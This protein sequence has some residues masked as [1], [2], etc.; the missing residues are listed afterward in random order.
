M[1]V[2]AITAA[3]LTSNNKSDTSQCDHPGSLTASNDGGC[4]LSCTPTANI[5][6]SQ[7][8][9]ATVESGTT[10]EFEGS[11]SNCTTIGD[12]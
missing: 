12:C 2:S 7:R 8:C 11:I 3:V 10:G 1:T 6:G 4:L 9:N 5:D